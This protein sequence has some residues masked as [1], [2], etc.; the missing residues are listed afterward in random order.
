MT[1]DLPSP[2]LLRKLLRYEPD[3]GKLFWLTRGNE[4]AP[5]LK[6][7]TIKTFN[8]TFAGKPA[9]DSAAENNGNYYK[10]GFVLGVPLKAHRVCWA[11]FYGN[12]P[13][14]VIDHINGNGLDNSIGNLR[15]VDV[16][17]NNKNAKRQNRGKCHVQGIT[18]HGRS[19]KW[20]VRIGGNAGQYL[21]LYKCLGAAIAVRLSAQV[22]NGYNINHGRVS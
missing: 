9:L 14:G 13:A 15:D 3:T 1:K 17:Q 6:E 5:N 7:A 8:K 22:K 20:Q 16:S 11:I 2:E 12:W 18:W 21:G 10:R 4:N 19:K